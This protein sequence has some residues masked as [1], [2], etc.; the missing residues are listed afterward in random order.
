MITWRSALPG[1]TP[2]KSLLEVGIN[3]MT[4]KRFKRLVEASPFTFTSYD[5]VPIRGLR[6]L[7]RPILQE[8]TTS[9]VRCRLAM[10]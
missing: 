3:K 10:A 9:I 2:K 4:V 5:V 7:A 1:K 6:W 8:V